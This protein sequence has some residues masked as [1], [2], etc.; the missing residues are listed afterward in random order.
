MLDLPSKSKFNLNTAFITVGFVQWIRQECVKQEFNKRYV[1]SYSKIATKSVQYCPSQ[2][3]N[4][5]KELPPENISNII[6]NLACYMDCVY[7]DSGA[8]FSTGLYPLFEVFLRKLDLCFHILEE[9]NPLMKLLCAL[10]KI[11]G[12]VGH[13]VST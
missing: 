2:N 10:F 4:E 12:V 8:C 6:A 5:R 3:L 1:L 11:P 7:Q 9:V 13:K